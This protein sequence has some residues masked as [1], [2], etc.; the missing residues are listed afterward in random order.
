MFLKSKHI[1][2]LIDKSQSVKHSDVKKVPEGG[3]PQMP[4]LG[5]YGM[6]QFYSQQPYLVPPDHQPTKPPSQSSMPPSSPAEYNKNKEPPLDLMT[7]SAQSNDPNN[8]KEANI[9]T[10]TGPGAPTPTKPISHF[11]PYK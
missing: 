8:V 5:G 3:P 4:P 1:C 6:Y 2:V 9:S 7:K 11:Y 10:S